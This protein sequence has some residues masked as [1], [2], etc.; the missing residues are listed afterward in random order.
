AARL[1]P[2]QSLAGVG[3]TTAQQIG[4]AGMQSAQNIGNTQ[5]AGSAAKASGYVGG[6]NA[7]NQALGAGMRYYQG[8]QMINQWGSPAQSPTTDMF[9]TWT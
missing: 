5:M 2:L 4:Q 7:L 8:N 3:Q 6:V 1:Q 9:P